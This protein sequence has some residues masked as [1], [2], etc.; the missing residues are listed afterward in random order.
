MR[1]D[2]EKYPSTDILIP[3]LLA[4][5]L[6]YFLQA[7]TAKESRNKLPSAADFVP[8]AEGDI[9]IEKRLKELDKEIE[10]V[11]ADD[12]AR[13]NELRREQAELLNEEIP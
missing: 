5:Q 9:D 2:M 8:W 3:E 1:E 6:A 13:R 10:A 12:E 7:N 4:Q 11:P